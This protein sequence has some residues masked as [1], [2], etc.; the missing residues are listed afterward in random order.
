[1]APASA[2]ASASAPSAPVTVAVR[3][4]VA[5]EHAVH[6][7][8]W[9]QTGTNLAGR[10]DGFLGSGWI[11]EG[12]HSD[13]W[14]MLYRFDSREHLDAWERSRERDAWLASGA[15]FAR[16]VERVHRTGIE[17]WFDEPLAR[18]AEPTTG[19]AGATV[20]GL[21]PEPDPVPPPP[22]RWKQMCVIFLGFLP[23]TLAINLLLALWPAWMELPLALRLTLT[24]ILMTP[25]MTFLVLP[26]LTRLMRPWLQAGARRAP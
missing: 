12:E 11:R 20:D 2:S 8:A 14:H 26:A 5:P 25:L 7:Q 19:I 4:S 6:A 22:P 24:T 13:V 21:D 23:L 10:F 17:G 18:A 16:E 9:V 3:R 1:M 15:S